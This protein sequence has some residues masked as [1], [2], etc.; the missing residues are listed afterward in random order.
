M[1]GFPNEQRREALAEHEAVI[2]AI[3]VVGLFSQ[4]S[5]MI[6]PLAG[7]CAVLCEAGYGQKAAD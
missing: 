2:K 7:G 4:W 3:E 6:R 1:F 5:G